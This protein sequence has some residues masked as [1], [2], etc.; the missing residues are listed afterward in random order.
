MYDESQIWEH[1][2]MNWALCTK[3]FLNFYMNVNKTS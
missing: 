3:Y 1:I 2:G